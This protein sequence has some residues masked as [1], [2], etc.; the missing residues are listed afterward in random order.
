MEQVVGIDV[1][2]ASIDVQLGTQ[3]QRSTHQRFAQNEQGFQQMHAWLCHQGAQGAH[4]CLEA[5]GTYSDAIAEFC[6]QH[7][8]RVSMANPARVH[9]FRI[10]EGI[11]TKTDRLD[12]WILACFCQQ[13]QP[14]LW[15]PPTPAQRQ[16]TVLVGRL[17]DLQQMQQQERNRLENQRLDQ[18]SRQEI[19]E[20]LAYLEAQI[21]RLK[22][23]LT[24]FKRQ[25]EGL[26]ED[27]ERLCSI[28]GIGELTA[29]R[30]LSV[31][32]DQQ[33]FATA[34][35][36]ASYVGV[37][38]TQHESG[39]SVHGKSQFKRAG[40]RQVRHWLYMCTLVFLRRDPACQHWYQE[41]LARGKCKMQAVVAVMRKLCHIV[42]G[43]YTHQQDYARE[44]AFPDWHPKR[45]EVL[46]A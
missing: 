23:R 33:T 25:E 10:S 2:K 27:C 29:L 31:L 11:T 6:H 5:T 42:H 46:A 30:L 4:V 28:V 17:D 7:G 22:D 3:K 14:A 24:T 41:L 8:Y 39:T 43:V 16:R 44:T 9:A 38:P 1:S 34:R 32:G 19:G 20:H 12:A 15:Q 13:K 26:K 21:K 35:A 37:T 45:P 18:Q 36:F 40:N